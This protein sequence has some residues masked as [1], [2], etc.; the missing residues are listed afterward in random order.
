[1]DAARGSA[2]GECFVWKFKVFALYA[3]TQSKVLLLGF[4]KIG[5]VLSMLVS[6]GVYWSA[7]GWKFGLGF[8]GSIY[9]HEMGHVA[10]LRRYGIAANPP[11]FIPG[12]GALVRLKQYP[13]TPE[14][15]ARVGLAGPIWGLGAAVAAYAL[16]LVTGGALWGAIARTGAWMNLF[17]LIPVWQL[18]GSRGFRALSRQQRWAV[19]LLSACAWFV[20]REAMLLLLA[21]SAGFRAWSS[22]EAPPRGDKRTLGEFALLV[23]A[24]GALAA[25]HVAIPSSNG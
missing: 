15:D 16:F 11:M 9:I 14:E 4:T 10:A 24:L 3:L 8:I 2:Q 13:R 6:L 19:V 1:M 20:T 17:N 12:F 25:I 23:V 7:L 18:D 21:L 5:T 22:K